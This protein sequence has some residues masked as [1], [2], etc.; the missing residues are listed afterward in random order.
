[1]PFLKKQIIK[2][3][4]RNVIKTGGERKLPLEQAFMFEVIFVI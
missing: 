4:L 2:S 3:K 1:M